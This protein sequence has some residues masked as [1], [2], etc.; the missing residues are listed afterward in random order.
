MSATRSPS[1][2]LRQ[3]GCRPL[4]TVLLAEIGRGPRQKLLIERVRW[5]T[6]IP[7]VV[8]ISTMMLADDGVTWKCAKRGAV[9]ESELEQVATILLKAK[10]DASLK[11][12]TGHE[13][14]SD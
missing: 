9:R 4:G 2:D 6:D 1:P 5:R 12:E 3:E 14:T 11:G 13:H 8:S 10:S 7:P